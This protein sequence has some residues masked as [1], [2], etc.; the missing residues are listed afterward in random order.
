MTI[1]EAVELILHAGAIGGTGEVFV[2]DMGRPVRILD[3]A[4]DLIRLTGLV[5]EQDIPIRIVGRR[6]GEKVKEDLLT[7]AEV[8]NTQKHGYFYTA[9][10][11][12]V[13][14]DDL[15][16]TI[17]RLRRAAD[18]GCDSRI[19]QLLQEI[20]P[21]FGPDSSAGCDAVS[22]LPPPRGDTAETLDELPQARGEG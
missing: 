14:L 4:Y 2:L 7:P 1:P 18:E 15:L 11:Q 20:V 8:E 9:H 19:I 3:L 17:A 22:L 12:A 13:S 5:P 10:A 21:A 6:P 16:P